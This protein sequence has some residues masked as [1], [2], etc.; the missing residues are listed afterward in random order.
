MP[1]VHRV[2]VEDPGH[3]LRVR[4]H[5]GR[6]NVLLGPDLVDDLGR[7]PAREALELP[8]RQLLGVADDS[9]LGTAE[10]QPHQRAL[11]RHPHRERLDLVARQ[12]R[13]IAD[14]ALRRPARDVVHHSIALKDVRRPV[15]HRDGDGHLDGLLALGEDA[16]QVV[17]DAER[18]TDS[19]ELSAGE[20]VRVLAEVRGR[21][22]GAH[23]LLRAARTMGGL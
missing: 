11:P 21:L 7:V 20:P 9:A 18:L 10:G 13:V 6:R 12:A 19:A 16:D 5:V 14:P 3:H 17:I 23:R 2:R 22:G 15:V 4:P 8:G 1:D